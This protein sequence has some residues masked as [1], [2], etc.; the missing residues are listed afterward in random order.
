MK[1]KKILLTTVLTFV[2]SG[3]GETNNKLN[4][5]YT[6]YQN[7]KDVDLEEKK[8]EPRW[9]GALKEAFLSSSAKK[10]IKKLWINLE[11]TGFSG[12]DPALM[13]LNGLKLLI[14]SYD[15]IISAGGAALGD[16]F[17]EIEYRSLPFHVH[18]IDMLMYS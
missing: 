12:Y 17:N 2:L 13:E 7:L 4:D 10:L 15:V 18:V 16:I 9:E 5:D 3:C 11:N 6:I 14:P 1:H 8:G